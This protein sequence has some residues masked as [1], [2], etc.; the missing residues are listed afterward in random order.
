[1]TSYSDSEAERTALCQKGQAN[2]L[3]FEL[4][5][6]WGQANAQTT[7]RQ[8]IKTD[9]LKQ[10]ETSAWTFL[11]QAHRKQLKVTAEHL[12]ARRC[13]SVCPLK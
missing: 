11:T 5:W 4:L 9:L 7:Q 10:G 8:L 13:A 6:G 12:T 3:L 2:K 1:M